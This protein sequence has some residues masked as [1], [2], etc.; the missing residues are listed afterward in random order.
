M[1]VV[2]PR[3]WFTLKAS[4]AAL[5][6]GFGAMYLP[7]YRWAAVR[8]LQTDDFARGVLIL[9][10][11][12][13]LVRVATLVLVPYCFGDEAGRDFFTERPVL[14]KWRSLCYF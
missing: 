4:Y 7:M 3:P 11:V 12:A 14:S 2:F 13:N 6:V 8:I 10:I 5:I 1:T 9:V